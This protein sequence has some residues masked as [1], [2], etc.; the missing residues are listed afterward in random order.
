MSPKHIVI[1]TSLYWPDLP[2]LTFWTPSLTTNAK[3][4]KIYPFPFIYSRR[5]YYTKIY[6]SGGNLVLKTRQN[7]RATQ[8]PLIWW[9]N[10]PLSSQ[11]H[12]K[13]Q[14]KGILINRPAIRCFLTKTNYWITAFSHSLIKDCRFKRSRKI[15]S[16]GSSVIVDAD[17]SS[18][19]ARREGNDTVL[20]LLL[21]FDDVR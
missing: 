18:V 3:C 10:A 11:L 2:T 4:W 14:V 19:A 8:A 16:P 15:I 6:N 20:S 13:F 9:Q 12:N 21:Q 1:W 5:E 7:C 17:V